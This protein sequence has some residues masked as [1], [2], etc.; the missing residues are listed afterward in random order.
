M[1]TSAQEQVE[2]GR[3]GTEGTP[4]GPGFPGL[5]VTQLYNEGWAGSV[6]FLTP[7]L[8]ISA[9][10]GRRRTGCVLLEIKQHLIPLF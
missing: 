4:V 10:G 7:P 3:S 5:G 8:A 9:L 1:G 2:E 6:I